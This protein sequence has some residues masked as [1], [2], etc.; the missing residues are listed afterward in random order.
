LRN[1]ELQKRLDGL[2]PGGGNVKE[3]ITHHVGKKQTE[4]HLSWTILPAAKMAI[5]EIDP[6]TGVPIIRTEKWKEEK[7]KSKN[8][9][10]KHS[11]E[12]DDS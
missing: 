4:Y 5:V 11:D 12:G 6:M 8:T 2:F 7:E 9:K 10:E 3:T 1:E